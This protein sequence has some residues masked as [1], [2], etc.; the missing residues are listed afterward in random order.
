MIVRHEKEARPADLSGET[1]VEGVVLLPLLTEK[2]GARHFSMRLF[3]LSPGGHT[4]FHAH[5]WEHEVFVIRGDG[6]VVGENQSHPLEPGCA[7]YVPEGEK[8][9]FQAGRSGMDFLCCI[10]L[11]N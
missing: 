7:V 9:R 1:D 8:H 4:P 10:H 2:D 6:E 11:V 5:A 3:R